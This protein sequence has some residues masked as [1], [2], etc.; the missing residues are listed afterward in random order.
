M[1]A[2]TLCALMLKAKRVFGSEQTFLSFP[3]SPMPY[4]PRDLDFF[5]QSS[6]D[7]TR[8]SVRKQIEFARQVNLIPTGEA[9]MPAASGFLWDAYRAVLTEADVAQ[10]A[11]S[12]N[13]ELAYQSACALLRDANGDDTDLVKAYKQ[14]R[15]AFIVSQEKYLA[16]KL[17]A[18]STTGSEREQWRSITE[19]AMKAEI[20]TQSVKWMLSGNK[21]KV[22]D[23][24]NLITILG[25]HSPA[26]ML[27]EWRSRC[28]PDIDQLT[29]P[30]DQTSAF[31]TS[32]S[33]AN[34]VADNAWCSFTLSPAEISTLLAG[35]LP[36]WRNTVLGDAAASPTQTVTFEFSS[37]A[38]VRPWF[39]ANAFKSRFWRFVDPSRQLSDGGDPPAGECTAY[40][41]GIVFARHIKTTGPAQPSGSSVGTIKQLAGLQFEMAALTRQSRP[42][43]G[44]AAIAL[45]PAISTA[46]P[47]SPT[48]ASATTAATT[49]AT[50]A[51]IHSPISPQRFAAGTLSAAPRVRDH[52]SPTSGADLNWDARL[53]KESVLK[54]DRLR[55]VH[56]FRPPI[57]MHPPVVA[58]APPAV[59]LPVPPPAPD[60][61]IY[62][63]AFICKRLGKTPNP[64]ASLS[65]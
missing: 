56:I 37:A 42:L 41:S 7:A 15:D 17:T 13:E 10:S 5:D 33:P 6:A 52:R 30:S 47:D 51:A 40:A 26:Q 19:P 55:G 9:W 4:T 57:K 11:R 31:V 60:E 8:L 28:N 29:D 14:H 54:I 39:D 1:D 63:L 12:E 61:T 65:W 18:E 58:P 27:T 22:E 35:A 53:T 36:E 38:I 43:P 24:Q 48:A 23:A 50:M 25:A 3:L 49:A 20:D 46:Q 64:D 34:A 16:A 21:T 32:F 45:K 44:I 62:V 2:A 59:P